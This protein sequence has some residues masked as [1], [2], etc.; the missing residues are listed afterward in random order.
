[1][2]RGNHRPDRHAD[3]DQK[4]LG[5]LQASLDRL[6]HRIGSTYTI[7]MRRMVSITGPRN[8]QQVAPFRSRRNHK[9]VSRRAVIQCDHEGTRGAQMPAGTGT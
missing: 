1:M 3:I 8:D 5:Q 2:D 4:R 7:K 6:G 9:L